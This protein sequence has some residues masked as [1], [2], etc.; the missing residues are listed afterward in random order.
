M[1]PISKPENGRIWAALAKVVSLKPLPNLVEVAKPLP[2]LVEVPTG[3]HLNLYQF[4]RG[5]GLKR[6]VNGLALSYGPKGGG[7]TFGGGI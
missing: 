4:G 2:D 1:V 7:I 5:L 6:V 3:T